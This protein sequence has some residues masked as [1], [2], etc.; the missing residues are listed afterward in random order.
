[1]LKYIEFDK[2]KVISNIHYPKIDDKNVKSFSE[3]NDLLFIGST[4]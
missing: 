2:I 1:M 4:H 3:R